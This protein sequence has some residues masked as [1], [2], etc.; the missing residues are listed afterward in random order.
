MA[1]CS[2]RKIAASLVALL[3]LL[4][5][6]QIIPITLRESPSYN[7]DFEFPLPIMPVKQPLT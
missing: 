4:A 7:H 2:L 5:N 3:P 1:V 6:A